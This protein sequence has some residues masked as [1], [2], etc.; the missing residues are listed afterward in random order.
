MKF[1][2]LM[3]LQTIG[4]KLPQKPAEG[5]TG[6]MKDRKNRL[7][8]DMLLMPSHEIASAIATPHQMATRPR[9][10]LASAYKDAMKNAPVLM[11]E[12]VSHS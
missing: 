7:I 5:T 4:L 12:N 11:E 1:S 6:L 10:K 3:L 9:N 2:F 8:N